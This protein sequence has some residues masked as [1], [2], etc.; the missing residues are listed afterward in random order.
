MPT[1]TNFIDTKGAYKMTYAEEC[2]LRA[3]MLLDAADGVEFQINDGEGGW[4][5]IP[6]PDFSVPLHQY[7]RKP[8]KVRHERVVLWIKFPKGGLWV[9]TFHTD[10]AADLFAR[11][12]DGEELKREVVWVEVEE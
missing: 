8:K 5:D 10:E 12:G 6:Q 11:R 7:R 1:M 2:R 9:G 3:Q 4:E